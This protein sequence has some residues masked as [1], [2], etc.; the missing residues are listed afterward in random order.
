MDTIRTSWHHAPPHVFCPD[1]NYMLTAGTYGKERL[2]NTN[3]K[4]SVVEKTI[5]SCL[6]KF[7][8]SPI[9]WAVMSNHYHLIIR[10][11]QKN[12]DN[13]KTMVK[14][15]HTKSA[16]ALNQM[17]GQKGRK[18]WFEYWDSCL[19]YENSYYARL[20]YV[21]NNPVHHG[22]VVNAEDYQHCSA[23][24]FK[25]NADKGIRKRLETYS[26]DKLKIPDAF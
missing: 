10:S 23:G 18:V 19:T 12:S 6:E 22:L 11:P 7:E 8:W 17:D 1:V 15:I 4:L 26:T 5:I 13:L 25:F 16:I 24:F 9:A 2:F 3:E 21:M 14:D 20:K